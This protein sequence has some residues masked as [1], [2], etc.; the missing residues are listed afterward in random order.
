MSEKLFDHT[1]LKGLMLFSE[2]YS[3]EQISREYLDGVLLANI[4]NGFE[5]AFTFYP[6]NSDKVKVRSQKIIKEVVSKYDQEA[7]NK[8]KSVLHI[9]VTHGFQLH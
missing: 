1:Q 4:E 6:E 3:Q 5:E 8:H 2:G 9:V 7:L